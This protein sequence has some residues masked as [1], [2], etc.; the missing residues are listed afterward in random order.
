V[1]EHLTIVATVLSS[2]GTL[3]TGIATWN[4]YRVSQ[5]QHTLAARQQR[6]EELRLKHELY[7]RR[8][9]VY[10][11]FK[12]FRGHIMVYADVKE[13]ALPNFLRGTADSDFLFQEEIPQYIEEVYRKALRLCTVSRQ[14]NEGNIP[15]GE[16]RNRLAHEDEDL[17][18]WFDEQSKV[19]RTKFKKYLTMETV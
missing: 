12:E 18:N 1:I 3:I 14:L 9:A 2:V 4:I 13:D 19:A 5:Q 17:L 16:A 10:Q 6:L 7:D 8:Y 11:A 15:V